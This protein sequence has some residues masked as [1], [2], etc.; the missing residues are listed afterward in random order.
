MSACGDRWGNAA[1]RRGYQGGEIR[2]RRRRLAN[3]NVFETALS[4][5][6]RIASVAVPSRRG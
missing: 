4:I 3:T 6:D 1:F 2:A 5:E